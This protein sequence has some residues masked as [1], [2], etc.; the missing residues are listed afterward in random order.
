VSVKTLLEGGRVVDPV[1]G[2]DE[3]TDVLVDG[4]RIAR[5]GRGAS[6]D[7]A[8]ADVINCAGL[9][10][11]PGFID[12]HV[13]LREP[14]QEYKETI[15]S[16]TAAAVAGGFTGVACMANTVPP[17]D[18]V[19][20]TQAILRI[21][22][23]SGLCRVWPIA[24]VTRGLEGKE[25]TEFGELRR[26]GAVALSDDGKPIA[27]AALLRRALEYA[28]MFDLPIIDHAEDPLLSGNGVMNEGWTAT[29]LGLRGIPAAAEDVHVARDAALAELTGAAI[30]V[31]H[32]STAHAL[33]VV[34]RAKKAGVRMTCEAAPHH[35]L[36]DDEAVGE[37]DT[38]CK[39]KPPL[40]A[41]ADV[42][43]VLKGL[44]DG[45]I[46]CIAS[47]HA[48]HHAD[49]KDVPFDEAA[50]GI[51]GLETTVSLCLHHLV[52][53]A[54]MPLTRLVELLSSNPARI[55]GVNAGTIAVGHPADVTVLDLGR[56]VTVDPATFRSKGRTTPFAGRTLR[57]AAVMTIVGGR[58][59]WSAENLV[60]SLR[61]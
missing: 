31:A 51:V 7:E 23:E 21:A 40:R 17:N 16:G 10:V 33:D 58:V 4:G 27:D 34:R 50:F 5:I 18:S 1:S 35:F 61:P 32:I 56:E 30:H 9:V 43:A 14:G 28:A 59:A 38:A 55:L 44:L 19:P 15:A 2:L 37:F 41:A 42:K 22:A 13:H 3:V 20:V 53:G 26:A 36:L 25:I 49:E 24:A 54:D 46:D 52:H 29:C 47:D 60:E 48:P 6:D 57:G 8:G 39:M 11:C 12:M 45:T